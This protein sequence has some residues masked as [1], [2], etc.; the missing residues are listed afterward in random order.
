MRKIETKA[1]KKLNLSEEVVKQLRKQKVLTKF[2]KNVGEIGWMKNFNS[3]PSAP[4]VL[5]NAFSWSMTPE[6]WVYWN[7][8]YCALAEEEEIRLAESK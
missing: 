8:V 5:E 4:Y 3:H 2:L 1:T 6:N 7:K